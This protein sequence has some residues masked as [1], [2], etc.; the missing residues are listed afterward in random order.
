MATTSP[1]GELYSSVFLADFGTGGAA[2]AAAAASAKALR[3]AD[4]LA[5]ATA[6]L[7]G[8]AASG[9]TGLVMVTVPPAFSTAATAAFEAPATVI[10]SAAVISPLARRRMP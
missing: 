5:L 4:A 6:F 10:V 9:A 2:A 7:P 3:F 1:N 8:G